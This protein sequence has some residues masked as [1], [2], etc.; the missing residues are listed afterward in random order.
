MTETRATPRVPAEVVPQ[1]RDR[2]PSAIEPVTTTLVTRPS[3]SHLAA[4]KIRAAE[5]H[6]RVATEPS[7]IQLRVGAGASCVGLPALERVCHVPSRLLAKTRVEA[8]TSKQPMG[9]GK[10]RIQGDCHFVTAT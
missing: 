5:S 9:H 8:K 7:R 1:T 6:E 10:I 3:S 4:G 2:I